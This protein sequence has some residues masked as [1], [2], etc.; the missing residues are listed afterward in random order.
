[1]QVCGHFFFTSDDGSCRNIRDSLVE[2]IWEGTFTV[3]SLD[4]MR[5]ASKPGVVDAWGVDD[6]D[7]FAIDCSWEKFD[8]VSTG[9]DALAD[10]LFFL[11]D[12]VDELDGGW[13]T[14]A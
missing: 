3:L 7:G 13:G 6:H 2:K 10:R 14:Q 8:L 1:M 11:H 9:I 4:M 5:A 12:E